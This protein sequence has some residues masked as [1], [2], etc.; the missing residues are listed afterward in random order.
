MAYKISKT[1][2]KGIIA[3]LMG[4]IASLVV[5]L[6]TLDATVGY[7]SVIVALLKMVENYLKHK[8]D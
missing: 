8:N 7:V 3:F 6:Q 4:G 1:I 2:E 5:Y